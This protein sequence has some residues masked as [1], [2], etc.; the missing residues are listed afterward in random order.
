MLAVKA[1][2]SVAPFSNFTHATDCQFSHCSPRGFLDL[3]CYESLDSSEDDFEERRMPCVE[4]EDSQFLLWNSNLLDLWETSDKPIK[5]EDNASSMEYD[6][7]EE[8]P[9]NLSLTGINPTEKQYVSDENKVV[10]ALIN[11]GYS[12]GDESPS[13]L[14][15]KSGQLQA[16]EWDSEALLDKGVLENSMV[17]GTPLDLSLTNNRISTNNQEVTWLEYLSTFD[18]TSCDPDM[19]IT[20]FEWRVKLPYYHAGN[21]DCPKMMSKR[22]SHYYSSRQQKQQT[23]IT[24]YLFVIEYYCAQSNISYSNLGSVAFAIKNGPEFETSHWEKGHKIPFSK[25]RSRKPGII[26]F[27]K[28]MLPLDIT[29][30]HLDARQPLCMVSDAVYNQSQKTS[31]NWLKEWGPDCRF[32]VEEKDLFDEAGRQKISTIIVVCNAPTSLNTILALKPISGLEG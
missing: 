7:G 18:Y 6:S 21:E 28:D 25:Y 14:S 24:Q 16:D 13:D 4:L 27:S 29:I 20:E 31:I 11:L 17:S 32:L 8:S 3:R 5:R 9:L 19:L 1:L 12:K 23:D 10:E 30:S 2:L 15:F 26:T 22:L